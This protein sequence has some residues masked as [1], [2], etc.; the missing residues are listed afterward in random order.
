MHTIFSIIVPTFNAEKS[1]IGT[2][3]SI[4]SQS[5]KNFELLIIDGDSVDNTVAQIKQYCKANGFEQYTI[6]SEKDRGIYDAM[7]NGISIAKG[8]FLYFI[9]SDDL[10]YSA[11][12]LK[13]VNTYIERFSSVDV[14]YGNVIRFDATNKTE[15]KFVR[16]YTLY[17]IKSLNKLIIFL[18]LGLC[19]Q[20][21][22]AKRDLF[23]TKFSLDYKL[24]S[25]FNW[26]LDLVEDKKR[27]RHINVTIA[28]YNI[29]GTSSDLVLLFNE[30]TAVFSAHYG[31]IV[32][33]LFRLLRKKRWMSAMK[34]SERNNFQKI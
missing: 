31:S 33:S 28:K 19:H 25:D 24:V 34:R 1:I 5:F 13:Q 3:S 6:I 23:S 30:L 11:D 22:F 18:K 20:A 21:F 14:F 12:I 4:I 26:I 2:L 32:S 7:N 17:N 8:Q 16:T 27:F 29:S 9:G 10:L 15:D